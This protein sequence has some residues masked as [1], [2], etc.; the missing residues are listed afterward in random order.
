[1][2]HEHSEHSTISRQSERFALSTGILLSHP[3]I[4]E[5]WSERESREKERKKVARWRESEREREA[6][7]ASLARKLATVTSNWYRCVSYKL[8]SPGIT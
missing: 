8:G 3:P 5:R 1:M 6:E 7:L 4:R 2:E